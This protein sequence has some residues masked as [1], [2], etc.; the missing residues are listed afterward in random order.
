MLPS[1]PMG[2]S[3]AGD[4]KEDLNFAVVF[5]S[6]CHGDSYNGDYKEGQTQAGFLE[7]S[8]IFGFK[9]QSQQKVVIK[10][11]GQ[12]HRLFFVVLKTD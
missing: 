12:M 3:Y 4:W 1:V 10:H 2:H 11:K 5:T 6:W 8:K 9:V 7:E